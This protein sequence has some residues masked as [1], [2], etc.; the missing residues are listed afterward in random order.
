M[1]YKIQESTLVAL[2]DAIREQVGNRGLTVGQMAEVIRQQLRYPNGTLEI[3][4]AGS[5]DV[6]DYAQARVSIGASAEGT[7]SY[8]WNPATR[9]L[10][11]EDSEPIQYV[12][13][14]V[15][16]DEGDEGDPGDEPGDE[17]WEDVELPDDPIH[18]S[19]PSYAVLNVD[20]GE[21]VT[22]YFMQS[23]PRAVTLYWGDGS[24]PET[25]EGEEVEVP[26]EHPA[27]D[28]WYSSRKW[29]AVAASHSYDAAGS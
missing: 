7:L 16:P 12:E 24:D 9:T 29:Y 13:E 10:E 15:Y 21:E 27:A 5:Y 28:G 26:F 18:E 3:D 6:S 4:E 20:G 2:A 19:D 17:P 25:Y 23:A 14:T 11:M 8:H 22:V 1:I